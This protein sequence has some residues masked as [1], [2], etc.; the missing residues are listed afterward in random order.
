MNTGLWPSEK[1]LTEDRVGTKNK[2]GPE[3]S[4]KSLLNSSRSEVEPKRE[5]G[6]TVT[7]RVSVGRLRL[8]E[9]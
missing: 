3:A 9:S 4:L 8:P 7:A 5:L 1:P 2:A 6:Y